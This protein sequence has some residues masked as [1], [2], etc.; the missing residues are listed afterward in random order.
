MRAQREYLLRRFFCI[1]AGNV[2]YS[3]HDEMEN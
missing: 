1:A 3:L 2:V